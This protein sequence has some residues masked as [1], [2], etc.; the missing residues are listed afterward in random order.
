MLSQGMTLR[1]AAEK[2][3][4]DVKTA[5][6]YRRLGRLPS[7]CRP[8]HTWRTREDP[9]ESVWDWVLEHLVVNPGLQAKTLFDDLQRKYPGRFQDGQLRTLQRHV[10]HWRATE[11]PPKEVFFSQ[12]HRPGR[13]CQSDFTHM[14]ELGITI[15]GRR[16]DH[17]VYHFVL[18]YSNWETTTICFSESF[19]SL[20]TGLQNALLELGGVPAEHRTDRLSSA[21]SNT[22]K[23]EEFTRRYA[24]LMAHYSLVPCKIRAGKPNENGDVEQRHYRFKMAVGQALMLRGSRDFASRQEYE[25]FLRK[26]L[27]QLNAGRC[28]RLALER[29]ELRP[30]PIRRMDD[31]THL[32]ARVNSGSVI[33]VC[34]NAYSVAS[35]LIGEQV[36]VRL[37]AEYLEVWYG[38]RKVE[39]LERL[40]GRGKHNV[41]YRH[42]IDWLVRKPG[43][44]ADYRYRKDLFPRTSFRMARD[45][46]KAHNPHSA[47]K[48]YLRILKLAATETESG[49]A[50]AIRVVLRN[51]EAISFE[52]IEGI[53]RSG[54]SI[55]PITQT[56]VRDVDLRAY[57]GLLGGTEEAP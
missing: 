48:E 16:F 18:P 2:V 26:L 39:T 46:L 4:I 31:C 57:D 40:R 54:R 32:I 8:E 13:L 7:Q 45:S 53:V 11:G 21:V 9:F 27:G 43:A 22:V 37:Y 23:P 50:D 24:G 17:L 47:D 38:Q 42:I 51:G 12:V 6:R 19:E 14:S 52:R 15:G 25:E 3:G 28:K 1:D 33:H 34:R 5:R 20:S 44:F 56:Q 29:K 30:L 55:P 49:V 41:N 35:R 36:R 10:K